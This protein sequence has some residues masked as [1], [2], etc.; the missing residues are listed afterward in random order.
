ML[1]QILGEV[2]DLDVLL[3]RLATE[4]AELGGDD[5]QRAGSL[6]SALRTDRSCSRALAS[7]LSSVGSIPGFADDTAGTIDE[8][9]QSRS[10]VTLDE[11]AGE[12][13]ARLSRAVRKLPDEPADEQLHAVRKQGVRG[14]RPSSPAGK[15][16]CGA[17]RSCRTCSA[18]TR[19]R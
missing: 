16:L 12:A 7:G 1:G 11:L 10:A 3:A 8:L 13:F 9:E 19:M 17:R 14:T 4:A 5:A 18:S 6:L 2:R 15:N